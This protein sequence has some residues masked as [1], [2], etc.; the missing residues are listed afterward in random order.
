MYVSYLIH[1]HWR[2]FRNLIVYGLNYKFGKFL[3]YSEIGGQERILRWTRE[4]NTFMRN[5]SASVSRLEKG[6]K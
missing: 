3:L 2:E 6:K 1:W 4:R 5:H